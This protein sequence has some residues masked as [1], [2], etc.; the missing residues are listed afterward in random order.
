MSPGALTLRRCTLAVVLTATAMLMLDI[1]VINTALP[2]IATDLHAGLSGVQWIVDAYTL[3]LAAT[4][5]TAGSL[6]DRFGRSACSRVDSPSSRPRPWGA[7]SRTASACSTR[8]APFR[9]SVRPCC[10]RHR[11]RSSP[12]RSPT[13]TAR[14]RALAA[15]GATIGASFAVGPLVGGALTTGLGSARD[16]LR[17][18]PAGARLP[19]RDARRDRESCDPNPR[20]QDWAGQSVLT[21]G[22]FL[23]VLSLLRGN[24]DG[25]SSPT[26]LLELAAGIALLVAFVVVEARSRAPMLPLALFR[27]R[28]FTGT[29]VAAFAISGSFFAVFLYTTLYLQ[30]V[31]GLSP[32]EAGLVYLPTTV[33]MFLVSGA[34]GALTGKVSSR[35]LIGGGLALVAAGLALMTLA[36]PDSSWVALLPGM[37]LAMIGT[38]GFNPALTTVVLSEASANESGLAAGV[39]DAFRQTGIAVG[40]AALGALIP[41]GRGT[42]PRLGGGVRRRPARHALGGGGAGGRRCRPGRE[43]HPHPGGR[44]GRGAR[45]SRT[46]ARCRADSGARP[47]V[48]SRLARRVPVRNRDFRR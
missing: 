32:I 37:M 34:T 46:G 24:T 15:Y 40:V 20:R 13:P 23:L 17:E 14:G 8:H 25:W 42:G 33:V 27:N 29:Q 44:G 43:A 7:G 28:S 1:A 45:G 16:L 4:V 30:V 3:A 48:V 12:M 39:N 26:I 31:L 6:A 9:A 38:G 11:S 47:V 2:H 35:L 21:A 22:L 18:R 5:L 36:G 41:A 19:R 10:S